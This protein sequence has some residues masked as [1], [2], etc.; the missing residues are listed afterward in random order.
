MENTMNMNDKKVFTEQ[1]DLTLSQLKEMC[2]DGDIVTNP[3][4]QRDYVYNNRLASK[5]IESILIGIPIPTIYLCQEDDETFS[6]IDGQQRITSFV[7][8]L[9]NDYQLTV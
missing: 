2:A 8:Y 9:N 4:Y 1:K 5:L 7:R 3:D 6:V